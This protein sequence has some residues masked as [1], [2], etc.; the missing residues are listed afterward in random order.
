MFTVTPQALFLPTQANLHFQL[1][2][3]LFLSF[4]SFFHSYFNTQILTKLLCPSTLSPHR[5]IRELQIPPPTF[6]GFICPST[7]LA[8]WMGLISVPKNPM[9]FSYLAFH[10]DH[11]PLCRWFCCWMQV[12]VPDAQ[13]AQT[14]RKCQ[15]LEQRKIYCRVMQGD[16][17]LVP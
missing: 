4:T 11:L 8:Y 13:R 10:Y 7:G 5:L 14:I 3:H 2:T 15:S 16:G 9:T 17:R 1:F 6:Q 12:C